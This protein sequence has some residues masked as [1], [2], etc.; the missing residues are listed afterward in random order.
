MANVHNC[1]VKSEKSEGT[2]FMSER[3]IDRGGVPRLDYA[4]GSFDLLAGL[5]KCS[6]ARKHLLPRTAWGVEETGVAASGEGTASGD[7]V[8]LLAAADI[9]LPNDPFVFRMAAAI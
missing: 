2:N 6:K 7:G 3:L 8:R 9:W 5:Q 4:R 1:R